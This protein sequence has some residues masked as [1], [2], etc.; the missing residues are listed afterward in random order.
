MIP[1]VLVFDHLAVI[2]QSW[3]VPFSAFP[4]RILGTIPVEDAIW[5]LLLGFF[6]ILFYEHFLDRGSDVVLHP[7]M[8]FVFAFFSVLLIVFF[9]VLAIRPDFHIPY[10]YF[11]GGIFLI[12]LPT[13]AMLAMHPEL[14]KKV[15]IT[16]AY[17]FPLGLL[18]ELVGLRLN[19]WSFPGTNFIGYVELLGYRFPFEEF[20]F[21][22]VLFAACVLAFYEFFDDDNR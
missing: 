14:I 20:F 19:Q 15:A 2:D 5:G 3:Y 7:H 8:R 21:Y 9:L 6:I 10:L 13:V 4:F 18:V 1:L 16:S 12:L 17:F 22:F 11:L